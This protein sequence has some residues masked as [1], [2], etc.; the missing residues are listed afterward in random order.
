MCI[1]DRVYTVNETDVKIISIEFAAAEETHVQFF[2]IVLVE[3][4]ANAAVQAGTAKGTVVVPVPSMAEDGTET[5]VNVSV[6]AELPVMVPVDGRVVACV[7]YVF[8]DEEILTHYPAETWGSGK[9]VL[10]LYFPIEELIPNFTN[11]FQVFLRLEGGSGQI[12]T[13]G[14]IASISGQGMAAAPAWDGKIALEET[15]SAFRIGA[16]LGERG[17]VETVGMETMEMC[18]RDRYESYGYIAQVCCC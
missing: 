8:N 9:H 2:A 16:G 5:T 3:V 12:D 17:F 10:A 6:E 15:V 11:T 1:R 13:G 14:C 7:R 4:S 18:I